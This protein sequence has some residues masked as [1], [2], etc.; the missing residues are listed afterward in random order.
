MEERLK[1]LRKSMDTNTFSRLSF[2]EQHRKKIR[3]KISKENESEDDI[4]LAVMQ[5]LVD[6]KTGFELVHLLRGRGIRT[7]EDNEGS[8]YALLHQ[9]EQDGCLYAS[10]NKTNVKYYQLSNKGRKRLQKSE[11]QATTKRFALQGLVEE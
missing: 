2:T 5:L 7:F 11:K 10:W 8:L 3:E 9:L 6:E 4:F 1:R